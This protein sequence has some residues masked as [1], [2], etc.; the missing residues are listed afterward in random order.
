MQPVHLIILTHGLYGSSLN[1]AAVKEELVNL[2]TPDIPLSPSTSTSASNSSD[3]AIETVIYLPEG[4]KGARTW[5]GIDVCAYRI[6]EEI[7]REIERLE[8]EGKDV[9]GF[10]VMGYSL[11]G[12]ISRYIIG[13][14]HSRQPSFFLRHKPIS[15]STAATPHLGVLK[16][17]TLA[18]TVVHTV[19]RQLFS[20]SGRQI[21]CLD[22]EPEWGGRGLLELMSD[23]VDHVFIQAL[24]LFPKVMI[25]A[26]GCQ[27]QTVPYPTASFSSQDP[28]SDLSTVDVET[29]DDHIVQSWKK[30]EQ[31][32]PD[33]LPVDHSMEV[34]EDG[35]EVQIQ[36]KVIKNPINRIRPNGKAGGGSLYLR[37]LWYFLGLS[38]IA[39]AITLHN[40]HSRKRIR[41]HRDSLDRQPLLVPSST[42]LADTMESATQEIRDTLSNSVRPSTSIDGTSTPP[43]SDPV[44]HGTSAPLL[45]TPAQKLMISNLNDAIP[46][47]ERVIAWFPWA[48]NSHAMLICRDTKRFPWQEDGRG[49]VRKWAKFTYQAGI[50]QIEGSDGSVRFDGRTGQ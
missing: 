36:I 41:S 18:N 44:E 13:I 15:F 43:L 45:L 46:H 9:V 47:A 38:T 26:N 19:G 10:S 20:R 25:I 1:L 17:G 8:D 28:F 4:I 27:D 40:F 7:D 48:Y 22:K 42:S 31:P 35:E 21:Y 23:P 39:G 3:R 37:H 30:V 50:D 24:K 6:V 14:L 16:Y 32:D 29:D 5:D 2:S 34:D 33:D 12:L 11:G 49:V